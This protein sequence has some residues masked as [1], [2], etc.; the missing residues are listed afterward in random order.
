[1][2]V[3]IVYIGGQV[4]LSIESET[5]IHVKVTLLF[6]DL[7][8]L[9]LIFISLYEWLLG[10]LIMG[11]LWSVLFGSLT[12]WNFC[13]KEII[14]ITKNALTY[15]Q[16]YGFYKTSAEHKP[17][18]RA[19]NISLIPVIEKSGQPHYQLIFESY[20]AQQ[21]PEEIYRRSLSISATDLECLKQNIRL[22]YFKKIKPDFVRQPYLLN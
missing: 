17:I 21:L 13:G 12:L 19:L 9:V 3:N 7:I 5:S 22:L 20:N 10:L 2:K 8:G 14:T 15:Q 11:I 4:N 1:M 18:H 16:Y 6:F